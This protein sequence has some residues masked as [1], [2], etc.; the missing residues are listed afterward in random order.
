VEVV[1]VAQTRKWEECPRCPKKFKTSEQLDR[2]Y[3]EHI[4][5]VDDSFYDDDSVT[6]TLVPGR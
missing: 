4:P 3:Q 2:H 1:I 5:E 6:I